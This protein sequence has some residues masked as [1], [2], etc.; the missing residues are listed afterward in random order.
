MTGSAALSAHTVFVM[1]QVGF[2]YR[3]S[4]GLAIGSDLGVELPLVA[5]SSGPP[6]AGQGVVHVLQKTPIPVLNL[7]RVGFVL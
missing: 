1:P 6:E 7:L 4:F 5:S 2:L 3:F